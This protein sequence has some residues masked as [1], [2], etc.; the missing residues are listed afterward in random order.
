M[1]LGIISE[2]RVR[3]SPRPVVATRL[4]VP[5]EPLRAAG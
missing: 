5:E 3:T 2:L 1:L 4:I